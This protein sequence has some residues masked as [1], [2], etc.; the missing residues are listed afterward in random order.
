VLSR[1]HVCEFDMS[2]GVLSNSWHERLAN[3]FDSPVSTSLDELVS[4]RGIALALQRSSRKKLRTNQSGAGVSKILGRGLDFAE[5]RAY[6]PGD[7][8]RMIDWN[9]TARSGNAHTKL[10]V[11]EKERPF[12]LVID[13]RAA[14][15]FAT[16]NMYKSQLAIRLAAMMGWCA[17]AANERVGGMVF[18]DG[19]H[20]EVKPD[21][22]RRGLMALFRA[23][24]RLAGNSAEASRDIAVTHGKDIPVSDPASLLNQLRRLQHIVHTGSSICILSDFSGFNESSESVLGSVLQGCDVLGCQIIDPLEQMLPETGRYAVASRVEKSRMSISTDNKNIRNH[25]ARR[26]A[27]RSERIEQFFRR[28]RG[29]FVA[30]STGDQLGN[31]VST[32][33]Q[34]TS[35]VSPAG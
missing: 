28:R 34:L 17:V 24:E 4:L 11:E 2:S 35:H 5:V 21:S 15:Q 19:E 1:S 8:V 18:S 7:D 33:L 23:C 14:M 20:I 13:Q 29:R 30:V 32:L 10:F 12:F 26:F 31:S 27:Q 25:Y 16:R 9:V 6:Q 3:R 22:G